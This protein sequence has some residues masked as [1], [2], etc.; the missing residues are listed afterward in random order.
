L[1][2]WLYSEAVDARAVSAAIASSRDGGKPQL[3]VIQGR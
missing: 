3:R 2:G 1:Q